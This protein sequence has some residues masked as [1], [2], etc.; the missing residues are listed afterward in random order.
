MAYNAY[1]FHVNKMKVASNRIYIT[2]YLKERK[3]FMTNIVRMPTSKRVREE[4]LI[5]YNKGVDII[6]E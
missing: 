3:F 6:R 2:Q 4:W 1:A 5:S